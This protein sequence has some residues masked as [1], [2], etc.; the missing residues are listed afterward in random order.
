MFRLGIKEYL[1]NFWFNF[2]SVII[3]AVMIISSTILIS[4]LAVQTKTYRYAKGYIG[5]KGEFISVA[6]EKYIDELKDVDKMMASSE[7]GIECF[8]NVQSVFK[9]LIYNERMQKYM[10]PILSEGK[11]VE[12]SKDTGVLHA[13]I[14]D[15]PY[16]IK[17]GDTIDAA[18]ITND[19][20]KNIKIHICGKI[21][22]GQKLCMVEGTQSKDMSIDDL[23]TVY[24]YEQLQEVIF[25]TTSSQ[26]KNMGIKPDITYG[27]I[28]VKYKDDISK[29]S[30]Y[31]NQDVIIENSL[32]MTNGHGSEF[33]KEIS[34]NKLKKTSDREEK[35][36]YAKYIP[37]ISVD[38]ILI[39]LCIMGISAVKTARSSKYYG[40]LFICG[41]KW[42]GGTI[43]TIIEMS[44]NSALALLL[45]IIMLIIHN[46]YMLFGKIFANINLV[47]VFIMLCMCIVT[48]ISSAVMA[49]NVMR[50]NTP[51]DILREN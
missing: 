40:K 12:K 23:F 27:N 47:Q 24:S 35:N 16:G 29:D 8:D 15:N 43:L 3:L 26:I 45:G 30:I 36:I 38:F 11:W 46:K 25:I 21:M 22:E 48:V 19:E 6:K 9:T 1:R 10:K 32:D 13:V 2:F 4:T 34:L 28:I 44:I 5:K 31:H 50:D 20:E 42:S 51:L 14:S 18:I 39:C 33:D 49:S 41:M 7:I 17:T 37:L